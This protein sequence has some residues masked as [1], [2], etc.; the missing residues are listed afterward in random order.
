MDARGR[1][2]LILGPMSSGKSTELLRRVRRNIAAGKR[3]LCISCR[4]DTRYSREEEEGKEEKPKITTHDQT[5]MDVHESCFS[6]RTLVQQRQGKREEGNDWPRDRYDMVAVEEGQFFPDLFWFCSYVA[7][8]CG[9][10]VLVAGLLTNMDGHAFP[11]M[12][13]LIS[14]GR[15][16]QITHLN[17]ICPYC[18]MDG[19]AHTRYVGPP[20]ALDADVNDQAGNLKNYK[21]ACRSCW[22]PPRKADPVK[23][24]VENV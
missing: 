4:K 24:Q 5:S 14:K 8:D 1:I 22:R 6:L 21:A 3:V 13:E 12:L 23:N 16:D 15:V 20:L 19:A 10:P 18:K 9:M 2:E 7:D 17:A 11:S